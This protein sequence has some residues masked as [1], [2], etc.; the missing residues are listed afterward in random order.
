MQDSDFDIPTNLRVIVPNGVKAVRVYFRTLQTITPSNLSGNL[1]QNQD[2]ANPIEDLTLPNE[3]LRLECDGCKMLQRIY[4]IPSTLLQFSVMNCPLLTLPSGL[5]LPHVGQFTLINCPLVSEIPALRAVT[6]FSVRRCPLI[7]T[8]PA[9]SENLTMFMVVDCP[10]TTLPTLDQLKKVDV[11]HIEIDHL[12]IGSV[13]RLND[14]LNKYPNIRRL[15]NTDNAI[16]I[17]LLEKGYVDTLTSAFK[18]DGTTSQIGLPG[19]YGTL[20]NLMHNPPSHAHLFDRMA[21]Y[22]RRNNIAKVRQEMKRRNELQEM[23]RRNELQKME[24]EDINNAGTK[25]QRKKRKRKRTTRNAN[26]SR[27]RLNK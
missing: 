18:P 16:K 3:L 22:A 21:D 23:K 25:K 27:N 9:L 12:D 24:L 17:R 20:S 11:F 13:I 4:N 5:Q 26:K 2:L 7:T 15:S 1:T 19:V 8:I 6:Q 10:I 14:L